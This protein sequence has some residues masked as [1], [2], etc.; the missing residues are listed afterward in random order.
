M[1]R[2][3]C[4]FGIALCVLSPTTA[5]AQDKGDMGLTIS[6]P[7]AIGLMWHASERLAIRPEF[8]FGLTETDGEGTLPDISSKSFA[9]GVSALLYTHRWDELRLYVS[10]RFTYSYATTSID[11]ESPLNITDSTLSSWTATGSIGA[12]YA[13]GTR[14]GVFAEAGLSYSS[15]QSETGLSSSPDRTTWA[16]GTRAAVGGILYF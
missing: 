2:T 8:S 15:Q 16:F 4:A 7:S 6:A 13:L 11:I 9:L 1:G 14:F 10:P 3:V 12:Q 5:W